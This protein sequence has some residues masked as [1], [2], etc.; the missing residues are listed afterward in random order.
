MT[1]PAD[2]LAD[3]LRL[4]CIPGVGTQG[5]RALLAAFGL[6]GHIF[7]AGRGALA[8]VVGG[9]AADA[10]LAVP[11]HED[12]ERTLA[13]ASE[14]GNRVLTLA[15]ADYPRQLFDITDPPVLLYVKGEPAL[16]SRPGIALVGARS[17]TAA[18]EAN[19][20]AFARTLAQQGLV[21]VSGLALGIDAAAHRGALAAGSTGAG[22]VAVIGT[23]IDRI[24]PARNAALAREIAAAGA[25]VSEFPLGTPPLQH[26]F[27]RRN[28]LI[29]GLAEGVLVVEAAL[30]SGS[31]ITA[32][33]ATETGREVFAIPGSIHS[34]LSRGCHRLIRDGAK[35]VETAE[36]VVEELRGRLGWPAPV[37]ASVKDRR[38]RGAVPA[39][40]AAPPRQAALALDGE[41]TRVLEA[42]GHDPVDL[43]T[44]AARCGLT[45]DALYAILLPLELEGRL[46]KLPG[47]RFQR[48]T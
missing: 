10:V 3:W 7:A 26:N 34:P 18:G 33:L 37:A 13:W 41:R 42:I 2:D 1:A 16:L 8:A 45:V 39:V 38:S 5:Q 36:D 43:D 31:L 4:A 24:Y 12:I 21:V 47:G 9:Q 27:P 19:A 28:R 23:G 44:I 46:A 30:G 32:R 48:I 11:A 20:E 6:P 35:L 22:T 15:D 17:A 25:V 40:P 14:A 29:A